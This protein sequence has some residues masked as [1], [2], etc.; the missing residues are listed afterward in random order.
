MKVMTWHK[1]KLKKKEKLFKQIQDDPAV[2]P[3]PPSCYWLSPT[4]TPPD[5]CVALT[6]KQEPKGSGWN[7][8]RQ[9]E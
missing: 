5:L 3:H 2:V 4:F 7:L 9:Q 1:R 6:C 8:E